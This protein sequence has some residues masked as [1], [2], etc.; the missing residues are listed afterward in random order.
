MAKTLR[1]QLASMASQWGAIP[2]EDGRS[3][4]SGRGVDL[5]SYEYWRSR[6][7]GGGVDIAESIFALASVAESIL[8]D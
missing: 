8:W 4:L 1:A 5:Q 7:C 6:L 3:R 2:V